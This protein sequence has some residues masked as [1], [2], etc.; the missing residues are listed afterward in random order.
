MA[1]YEELY[2]RILQT[3]Q[4]DD[5]IRAVTLEGS[6]VTPGA[7]HDT[8]SDFDVTFFVTDIREFSKDHDY[9]KRFGDI[10]IQQLPEDYYAHPYDY[11]GRENFA[12]LTQF[13]D[14]NRIDLTFTD[15]CHM[16]KQLEFREPRKVLI[17]KDHF[18]QLKDITTNEAFYIRKP[19]EFEFFGTVNEFRWVSNYAT[20][21]LCRHE[22]YYARRIM[23]EY[24]MNMLLKMLNWK[25]GLE[26]DFQVTTGAN[27]KYLKKYL[28][29]EE[30]QR[31][32]GIFAS[33]DYDDMWKKL[34]LM[35]DYF[36]ELAGYVAEHLYFPEER[37]EAEN[38]RQFMEDRFQ[39]FYKVD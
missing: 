15:V 34:F 21:G 30:M 32:M 25:I 11:E 12:F 3:G 28:S 33:G 16:E 31:F 8:F 26:H 24:M 6:G 1:T 14:G 4:D 5:R 17:N 9:M 18:P 35:Y 23:E 27:C 37:T 13:K 22:F 20:K 38:V 36:H 19:S 10:L 39:S 29:N 7:V 2:E